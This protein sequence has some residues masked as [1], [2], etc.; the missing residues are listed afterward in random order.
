MDDIPDRHQLQFLK[1]ISRNNDRSQI[2]IKKS[3]G[4]VDKYSRA[5]CITQRAKLRFAGAQRFLDLLSFGNVL[6]NRHQDC[7]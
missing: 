4:L 5:R 7:R 1:A 3:V 6:E 2:G